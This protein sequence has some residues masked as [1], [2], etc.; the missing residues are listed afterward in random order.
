MDARTLSGTGGTRH[1]AWAAL[2]LALVACGESTHNVG[3]LKAASSVAPSGTMG[4]PNGTNGGSG[5]APSMSGSGSHPGMTGR[6]N[7][8][9]SGD[10][11][12]GG[13]Q[14]PILD[15]GSSTVQELDAGHVEPIVPPV[16]SGD[17][18]PA[19]RRELD[20]Y[21]IVD[22][23]ITIPP[24]TWAYLIGGMRRYIADPRTSGTGVGIGFLGVPC[25]MTMQ[26]DPR[27]NPYITPSASIGLLPG[28]RDALDLAIDKAP[29]W[30]SSPLQAAIEG[31]LIYVR[32][33]SSSF[34][35]RKIALVLV[36]DSA[37]DTAACFNIS[38]DITSLTKAV[39]GGLTGD[40]SIQTYVLAV[41]DG[42]TFQLTLQIPTLTGAMFS[43]TPLPA[44]N[45][46]AVAGGTSKAFAY[47]PSREDDMTKPSPFT[48]AM[49]KV[50]QE[51]EP[52]EFMIPDGVPDSTDGNWLLVNGSIDPL[53]HLGSEADCGDGYW[54][55][56]T[57]D[58]TRFA[59]LCSNTC[60]DVKN[61]HAELSWVSGCPTAP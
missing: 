11:S 59:H 34:P 14:A 36:T 8:G 17:I 61:A 57:S 39:M 43:T 5:A 12:P 2:V 25:P 24:N 30:N 53:Q 45:K 4:A 58:G 51:A 16:C 55:L 1:S 31:S 18:T 32:S 28:N 26:T 40:P 13:T 3:H 48:D 52:C 44:L 33:F 50:Q 56:K 7:P 47:Y 15:G 49:L 19:T 41:V 6:P 54:L 60:A 20:L 10:Q 46:I 38:S 37:T 21:L 35:Q 29:V 42:D 22:T 27:S 23:N 9:S